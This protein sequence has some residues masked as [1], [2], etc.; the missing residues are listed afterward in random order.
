MK[1][2]ES[3]AIALE[4]KGRPAKYNTYTPGQRALLLLSMEQRQPPFITVKHGTAI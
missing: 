3:V 4:M 2:N 1:A